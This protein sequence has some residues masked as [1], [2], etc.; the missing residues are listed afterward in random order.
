MMKM[1][2]NKIYRYI[3]GEANEADKL[4]VAG[5]I[6]QSKENSL[7]FA[8]M[9]ADYVFDSMPYREIGEE[10]VKRVMN[11]VVPRVRFTGILTKVAAVLFIPLVLF[12]LYQQISNTNNLPESPVTKVIIPEQKGVSTLYTVNKGVKG[13]I[14]LPDG[15]KVWLNS[16]STLRCPDRF[17]STARVLELTGEGYFYVLSNKEWPMFVKSSKGVTVKVT[18]TE[19]NIS[20]YDNDKELK[21]TLVSGIASLIKEKSNQEIP[22]KVNEEVIIPDDPAVKGLKRY[23]DINLNT[24]WKDGN[25]IF[26]NT[27][28]EEVIKK[29]ERWYGI[30]F[31]VNNNDILKY[32]FT[33]TFS[34]ESVTQVLEL[35]KITSNIGYSIKDKNV[36]LFFR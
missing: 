26:D 5:W 23:A 33:A 11:R 35:L 34:S 28:M 13:L 9:K 18:G 22:V 32:C 7:M 4:E 17:D 8:S 36:T 25:L 19:F 29:M 2:E 16:N 10:K 20:S 21:F 3:R 24:G 15:S 30:T 6:E 14:D 1:D 12:T 27:P 31:S